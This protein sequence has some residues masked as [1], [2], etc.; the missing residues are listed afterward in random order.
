MPLDRYFKGHG[1]KV[2]ANMKKQ[3]G[4]KKGEQVFYATVN[5]RKEKASSSAMDKL[6]KGK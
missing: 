5:S 6:R 4:S 3:Y 2:M 1:E